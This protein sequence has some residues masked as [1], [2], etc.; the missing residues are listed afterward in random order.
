MD[1]RR[2]KASRVAVESGDL[3]LAG[4]RGSGEERIPSSS[5]RRVG[6]EKRYS[7]ALVVLVIAMALLSLYT[8]ELFHTMLVLLMLGVTLATREE[9]L[10]VEMYD[11]RVLE[12]AARDRGSVRRTAKELSELLTR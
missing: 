2:V 11:G 1:R 10:V 9:V 12:I 8:Q 6:L 4:A 7:R 5:I 3:V